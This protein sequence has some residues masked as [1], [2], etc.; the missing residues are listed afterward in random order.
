MTESSPT[1]SLRLPQTARERLDRATAK[2]R[3]SRSF[4]MMR[5]LERHLDEIEREEAQPHARRALSTLLALGGA[6]APKAGPRS[7]KEIDAHIRWLRENG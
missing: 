3:R 4:L 1:M 2:T 5:A 6:G 7:A